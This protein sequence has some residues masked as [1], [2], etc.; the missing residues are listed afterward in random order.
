[1]LTNDTLLH[2]IFQTRMLERKWGR[3]VRKMEKNNA[4]YLQ[5][6]KL[7]ANHLRNKSQS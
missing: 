4:R 2:V 7:R 5:I 1:M 3:K 6:Y